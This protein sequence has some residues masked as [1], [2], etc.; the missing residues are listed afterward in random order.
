MQSSGERLE[1][2]QRKAASFVFT[3][4][5]CGSSVLGYAPTG[6]YARKPAPGGS[7]AAAGARPDATAGPPAGRPGDGHRADAGGL[8]IGR[9]MAISGAAASPNMGYHSSPLVAFA[10]SFFNVRLGWW[11][12]NPRVPTEVVAHAEADRAHPHAGGKED[13]DARGRDDASGDAGAKAK[14][15]AQQAYETWERDEPRAVETLLAETLART[16]E[17]SEFVYL[18]DGGHFENLGLYEMVRRRCRRIVVVDAT[19]DPGYCHEDLLSALRKVRIDFG[20]SIVFPLGLPT[21]A[22]CRRHGHP[23]ALG[24]VHYADADGCEPPGV[25]LPGTIL[26]LKPALW[27]ALPPDVLRYAETSRP[28]KAVLP[29]RDR[30]GEPEASF[31][32]QST[33]DQF[34]DEA[35]FE[36]YRLLG[37]LT[38]LQAFGEAGRWPEG[39]GPD[40][41]EPPPP[42]A[43]SPGVGTRPAAAPARPRRRAPLSAAHA[44]AR[45]RQAR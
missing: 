14:A 10:M 20:I 1:W 7:A 28:K 13:R 29:L 19:Q 41:R 3:P 6:R 36:S 25:I 21:A 43:A 26:Y 37:L 17:G 40:H 23:W 34:F 12:P 30:S 38:V 42:V 45:R 44:A 9:A 32:H 35:Q 4:R 16:H 11:L 24:Q 2:Q 33:A 39:S 31:P 15:D 5:C 18:S 22:S 27:D 8:S